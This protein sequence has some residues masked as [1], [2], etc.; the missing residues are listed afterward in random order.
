MLV[1]HVAPVILKKL[2]VNRLAATEPVFNV[3]PEADSLF[4]EL[5]AKMH[6]FAAIQR[7]EVHKPGLNI[8][9]LATRLK[10][11]VNRAL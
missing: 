3:V 8:F 11:A 1:G 9:D 2:A 5:P 7:R 6:F 4:A 10:N